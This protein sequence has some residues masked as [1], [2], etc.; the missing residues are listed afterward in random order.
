MANELDVGSIVLQIRANAHGLQQG[1]KTLMDSLGVAEVETAKAGA[2]IDTSTRKM[3]KSVQDSSAAQ[4]A[5]YAAVAAAATKTFMIVVNAIDAGIRASERYKASMIGLSS[6]A[7]GIGLGT[8]RV[9]Q[10]LDGLVDSFFD[11]SA[12]ATSLKNLLSRGYSLEQATNT[13]KRLKDTAAFG[14]QA[15]LS[16][17]EAVQTATEGL[18]NEN[19]ILVDNAGVTKNVAKMWEEYARKIGVATTSLTQAQKVEAEYQ[20]IIHETQYQV[21]D[22]AKASDTLSGAQAEAARNSL[23]LSEAFGDAMTPAVKILTESQNE[24]LSS[25]TNIVRSSPGFVAGLTSTGIAI[26]GLMV[27][28]KVAQAFKAFNANLQAAAGGVTIFGVAMK[29]AFPL[30]A[31]FAVALGVLT[32]ALTSAAKAREE[33]ARK[34]EEA[35]NKERERIR[36]IE[37]EADTLKTLYTRYEELAGKQNRSIQESN[38]LAELQNKLKTQYGISADALDG[39]AGSYHNTAEAARKLYKEQLKQLSGDRKAAVA[40]AQAAM[41][42]TRVRQL[43]RIIELQD[44]H[45]KV[46]ALFKDE[47]AKGWQANESLLDNYLEKLVQIQKELDNLGNSTGIDTRGLAITAGDFGK[48]AK[49]ALSALSPADTKEYEDAFANLIRTSMDKAALEA[50]IGGA[51]VNDKVKTVLDGVFF[52]YAKGQDYAIFDID[53]FVDQYA[54]ALNSAELSPAIKAMEDLNTRIMAGGQISDAEIPAIQKYY[55]QLEDYAAKTSQAMGGDMRYFEAIM[56]ALAPAFAAVT[57]Q[58]NAVEEATVKLQETIRSTRIG[59]LISDDAAEAQ[60]A[61]DDIIKANEELEKQIRTTGEDI[62]KETSIIEALELIKQSMTDVAIVSEEL[63]SAAKDNLEQYGVAIPETMQAA[64]ESIINHKAEIQSLQYDSQTAYEAMIMQIQLLEGALLNLHNSG[65]GESAQAAKLEALI[66]KLKEAEAYAEQVAQKG[67]EIPVKV[68]TDEID[69]SRFEAGL[70]SA[71]DASKRLQGALDKA[72]KEAKQLNTEL[73]KKINLANR[74]AEVQRIADAQ[75]AG[76][77][78]AEEWAFAQREAAEILRYT[79]D[80]AVEMSQIA[81]IALQRIQAELQKIGVDATTAGNLIARISTIAA[82][83]PSLNINV[84]PAIR[85]INALASVWNALAGSFLGRLMGLKKIGISGGYSGGGSSRGGSVSQPT[86]S[87][88]KLA[89]DALVHDV[90]MGRLSLEAELRKLESIRWLAQDIDERRDIDERIYEKRNEIREKAIQ[91]NY[92]YIDHMKA[93]NRM[94]AE[95]EKAFLENMVNLYSTMT[96]EE[97]REYKEKLH[98]ATQRSIDESFNW[99]MALLDHKKNMGEL[100][101]EQE[102]AN[103]E[104]IKKTHELSSENLMA[105]E[106]RLYSVRNQMRDENLAKEKSSIQ[107]AYGVLTAALKKRMTIERDAQVKAI[108]DRISALDEL[109]KAENEAARVDD[110]QRQLRE[111]QRLLSVTKSA[112]KRREL[113]EEIEKMQADEELRQKQLAREA[114][115]DSLQAQKKAIQE[116]YASLM[117]EEN[118]RQEALRMVMS[119]NL[120]AMTDLIASYGDA[121]KDAGAKLAEYLTEGIAGKSAPII[122]T[123]NRLNEA[124]QSTVY[125]QLTTL[126]FPSATNLGGITINMNG[127]TVREDADIDRLADAFY[128]KVLAAGR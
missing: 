127:L 89:L 29:S 117:S 20:G 91:D 64:D 2:S 9:Q 10:E 80:S 107:E 103:L 11:A 59:E 46:L 33:E 93:I 27:V 99:D 47:D 92:D 44:E 54:Q 45:N 106:E 56:A 37:K 52:D 28:T 13:I 75:L 17:A 43:E 40:S 31:G 126:K 7:Q 65:Q 109:T 104:R 35:A 70:E 53:G 15:N 25:I 3:T 49:E 96:L 18:K 4:A 94:T 55:E 74:V 61:Y 124:L 32:G 5:A 108:D 51:R 122:R 86:T 71:E 30:L 105:I 22:L 12:A 8:D 14:R 95:Q 120:Q 24:L 78:S 110:F 19:S 88:F 114:E 72:E 38:E 85:A 39:L 81:A 1:M 98:D 62:S 128:K 76:K 77:A 73:S 116:R 102:I 84:S 48:A 112:R 67:F 115:K 34:A 82:S 97:Q 125:E 100:T 119:N 42:N 121:W 123:I 16:L 68:T 118:I 58:I 41:D 63:L 87:P 79:G 6:V 111:K 36:G 23:L 83:T 66:A 90:K 60:K 101:L 69:M 57:P 21:G 26:T 50:E 113:T